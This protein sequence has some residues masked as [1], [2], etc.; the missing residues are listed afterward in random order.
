MTPR[1]VTPPGHLEASPFTGVIEGL[2]IPRPAAGTRE[3]FDSRRFRLHHQS[4]RCRA[5]AQLC[6]FLYCAT[7]AACTAVLASTT[8]GSPS[9]ATNFRFVPSV[10]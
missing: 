3:G 8:G 1:R 4:W 10:A 5:Q 2:Y 6:V 7:I 9:T